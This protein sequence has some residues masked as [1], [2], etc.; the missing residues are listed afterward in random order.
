[1]KRLMY[2]LLLCLPF[3]VVSCDKSSA[4]KPSG[5]DD[6]SSEEDS[7]EGEKTTSS[8]SMPSSGAASGMSTSGMT[9]KGSGSTT[10]KDGGKK[11]GEGSGEKTKSEGEGGK[12]SE[13]SKSETTSSEE[14]TTTTTEEAPK[15]TNKKVTVI[16]PLKAAKGED[17]YP[18]IPAKGLR[19]RVDVESSDEKDED[20]LGSNLVDKEVELKDGKFEF[21]IPA[22]N[23][24][25]DFGDRSYTF[26]TTALYV[27][28]DG[29]KEFN[30][31]DIAIA[32]ASPVIVYA[33]P[34]NAAGHEEWMLVKKTETGSFA[35][36]DLFLSELATARVDNIKVSNGGKIGGIRAD[37]DENVSA[38]ATLSPDEAKEFPKD[39][40]STPRVLDARFAASSDKGF[41]EIPV[42]TATGW[43][44]ERRE[45][46]LRGGFSEIGIGTFVGYKNPAGQPASGMSSTSEVVTYICYGKESKLKTV[47]Y[48]INPENWIVSSNGLWRALVHGFQPGWN[49][50]AYRYNEKDKGYRLINVLKGSEW[51]KL[52]INKKCNDP[53]LPGQKPKDDSS[54]SGT[55]TDTGTDSSGTGTGG[56]APTPWAQPRLD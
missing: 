8:A 37:I 23:L 17:A 34:G 15:Q 33:K 52:G 54:G 22:P 27:D 6:S 39:L 51:L 42:G 19:F 13:G 29:N 40:K 56:F 21:E 45:D 5:D 20:G 16:V 43:P 32:G 35:P 55:G 30:K 12:S 9:G 11:S 41:W 53:L 36:A 3:V 47:L 10:S 24:E 1:M 14:E 48:W 4:K 38:I 44:A 46:G 2:P 49:L 18:E 26:L 31:G 28:K 25:K 50:V 7:N